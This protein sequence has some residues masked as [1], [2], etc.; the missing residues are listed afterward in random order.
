MTGFIIVV[1]MIKNIDKITSLSRWNE[2]TLPFNT[3][4]KVAFE[5]KTLSE[6]NLY[7]VCY[8]ICKSL[9]QRND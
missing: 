4:T 6:R 1:D 7:T 2:K 5:A 9:Y 8:E 3:D